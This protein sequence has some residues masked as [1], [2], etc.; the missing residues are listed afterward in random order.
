MRLD[1]E[2]LTYKTAAPSINLGGT[3]NSYNTSSTYDTVHRSVV[4]K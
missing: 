2:A 4:G 1:T 3:I